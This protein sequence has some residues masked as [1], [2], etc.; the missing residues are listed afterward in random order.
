MAQRERHLIKM[1]ISI[2]RRLFQEAGL[3]QGHQATSSNVPGL[4]QGLRGRNVDAL[5][6][7]CK[8]RVHRVHSCNQEAEGDCQEVDTSAPAGDPESASWLDVLQGGSPGDS[9]GGY[10]WNKSDRLEELR[11]DQDQGSG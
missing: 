11:A 4:H 2:H 1:F 5:R 10:S 8:N 7:E 6:A 3:Q 9:R